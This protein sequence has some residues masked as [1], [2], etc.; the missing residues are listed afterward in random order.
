MTYQNQA[1]SSVMAGV[2]QYTRP[3]MRSMG[4]MNP[5][6]L[7]FLGRAMSLEF[8]A[9]Q[10]YLA[11]AALCQKRTENDFAEQFVQ[12]ANEEFRHASQLTE[13]MVDH[14]ALPSGSIL[15]PAKPAFNIVEALSICELNELQLINLYEQAYSLSSNLGMGADAELFGTLYEEEV[16]QLNRIRQWSADYVA[17]MHAPQPMN[18]G[19]V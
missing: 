14:G 6:V 10:Q 4:M 15:S 16:A 19:F 12:L 18:K 11:H 17:R 13:R 9:A 3:E 1:R 7:G 8:S 2:G 5:Q